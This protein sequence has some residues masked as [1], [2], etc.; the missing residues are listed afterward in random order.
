MHHVVTTFF[1]LLDLMYIVE[2]CLDIDKYRFALPWVVCIAGMG[3]CKF[4]F[5]RDVFSCYGEALVNHRLV[6]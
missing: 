5:V 2:L 3:A 6:S 4:S 1:L